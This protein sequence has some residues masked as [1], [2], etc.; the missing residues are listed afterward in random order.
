[1]VFVRGVSQLS[2]RALPAGVG[3]L[4]IWDRQMLGQSA[5]K[6]AMSSALVAGLPVTPHRPPIDS[7]RL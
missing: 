3:W 5:T 6:F 1:M 2:L 4:P 7:E